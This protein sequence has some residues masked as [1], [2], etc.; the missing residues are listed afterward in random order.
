MSATEISYRPAGPADALCISMLGTQV[1]LDT[2]APDGLRPELAREVL[3]NFSLPAIEEQLALPSMSF[4]L[5]ERAGHLIGFAQLTHG[6][7]HVLVA[8]DR[9]TEL[10]RLYVQERFT[11][12][13]IGQV[14]L[15]G[16]EELAARHGAAVLWLTAWVGNPRATAYYPKRGYDDVG[17]T[18]YTFEDDHYENR[19]FIKELTQTG[20]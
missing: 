5:A 17:M 9:S 20:V 8:Y 1:F 10:N 7:R 16:A 18:M 6:A 11:S 4:I 13:G 19:V 2:Y 3:Q 12:Q 15:Q 14:L